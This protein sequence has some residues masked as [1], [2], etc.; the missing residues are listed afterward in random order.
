MVE[1]FRSIHDMHECAINR[2]VVN[3]GE[4]I[5]QR[6]F[7]Y[8]V[9]C[10]H[11]DR[12]QVDEF[13]LRRCTSVLL[14]LLLLWASRLLVCCQFIILSSDLTLNYSYSDTSCRPRA[15]CQFQR[16]HRPRSGSLNQTRP[17]KHT[18]HTSIR[19]RPLRHRRHF[20]SRRL[21]QRQQPRH[22]QRRR[23]TVPRSMSR[24]MPPC[25]PCTL[26]WLWLWWRFRRP[27]GETVRLWFD[28]VSTS[29]PMW[30]VSCEC[31]SCHEGAVGPGFTTWVK[32]KSRLFF[33]CLFSVACW[34]RYMS[35]TELQRLCDIRNGIT[36]TSTG[37]AT[38]TS[39]TTTTSP[40]NTAPGGSTTNPTTTTGTTAASDS[41]GTSEGSQQG[42]NGASG[43]NIPGGLPVAFGMVAMGLGTMMI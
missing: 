27:T 3:R 4:W 30:R 43:M 37:T 22:R 16:T 6:V 2:V 36:G 11:S 25:P 26:R 19:R 5:K 18:P 14:W 7:F 31:W 13:D 29:E 34:R 23:Q 20:R 24:Y 8:L 21:R 35:S 12:Q 10:P 42:T 32:G 9:L 40:T 15:W 17:H 1:V 38:R 39:T 28:V 33:S 41:T